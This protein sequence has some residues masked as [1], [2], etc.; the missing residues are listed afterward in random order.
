MALRRWM[1]VVA[2]GSG[3]RMGAQLPKQF[4]PVAGRPVLMHT[5]GRFFS[6]DPEMQ[7]VLA[8]PEA[9]ADEWR[10]LVTAHNFN[11]PHLLV[12][13]GATRTLSVR[14][15]LAAVSDADCII[16]IHDGVRPFF[17]ANMI[18]R[19]MAAAE[20]HGAAVPVVPVVQS[21]REVKG[22]DNHAVDRSMYRA[23]QTPQCFRAEVLRAAYDAL[24]G[25]DHSDDATVVEHAGHTISMVAGDEMNVKITTPTDMRLAEFLISE[26]L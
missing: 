12:N 19:V 11:V 9:W 25:D 7:I 8:L 5:L 3:T 15:A 22:N 14:N 13:G 17:T 16:G 6:I 2:G 20:L 1:L 24:K 26:E 10:A 18:D 21:L 23:V 4:L